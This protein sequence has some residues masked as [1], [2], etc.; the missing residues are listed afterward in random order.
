MCHDT[1]QGS[2]P[3]SHLRRIEYEW[4]AANAVHY[5]MGQK[6]YI[7]AIYAQKRTQLL[8]EIATTLTMLLSRRRV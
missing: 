4:M 8:E 5:R 1:I 7:I 2:C 3:T 6:Q